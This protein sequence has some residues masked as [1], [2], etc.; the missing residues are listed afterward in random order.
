[1]KTYFSPVI[2]L[3]RLVSALP[4]SWILALG[5][6]LSGIWFYLIP[7]RKK[8]ALE[9]IHRVF[10]DT[11]TLAEQHAM[12]RRSMR[13]QVLYGLDVLRA[14][15]VT[16]EESRRRIEVQ[17]VENFLQ[18]YAGGKGF[19]AVSAHVDSLDLSIMSQALEGRKLT[20][21]A[22][23]L[24][25][26]P[27]NDFVA[28]IRSRTGAE[29]LDT[30]GVKEAIRQALHNN[31]MI[32]MAIDQHMSSH[33]GVVCSFFGALASTTPAP[34]RFALEQGCPIIP[35]II[36]RKGFSDYHILKIEEPFILEMPHESLEENI[37]HNTERLNRFVERWIRDCPD[38]WLWMHKRWKVQENPK[39]WTIPPALQHLLPQPP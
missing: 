24:S 37:W 29:L 15:Y 11:L 36:N 10:G 28:L 6:F 4:V 38:Q 32:C 12:L 1:M 33:R 27:A 17:G 2:L 19:I 16:V 39:G 20:C 9:N 14:P 30:S 18:A 7:I 3:S 25:W 5:W 8:I 13:H 23:K 21:I 26:S 34:V 22:K 31:R 35:L